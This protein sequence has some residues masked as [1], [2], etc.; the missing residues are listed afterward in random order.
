MEYSA[1]ISECDCERKPNCA[2]D[3]MAYTPPAYPSPNLTVP[4]IAC[5]PALVV[6]SIIPVTVALALTCWPVHVAVRSRH[7]PTVSSLFRKGPNRQQHRPVRDAAW[8][9]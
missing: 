4:V 6:T 3:R 8:P 9:W 2:R 7:D 5:I 1:G